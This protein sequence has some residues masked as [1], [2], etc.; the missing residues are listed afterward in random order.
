MLLFLGQ[1]AAEDQDQWTGAL[2]EIWQGEQLQLSTTVDDLGAFRSDSMEP[3]SKEL[4]ITPRDG[5]RIVV[6]NLIL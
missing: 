5:S 1:L 3:G 4:R 6:L 2:V